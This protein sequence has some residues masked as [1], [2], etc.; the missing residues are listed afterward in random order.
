VPA[1][2]NSDLLKVRALFEEYWNSF[3]FP[4]SLQ[5]FATEVAGLPGQYEAPGGRLGLA[6]VAEEA[7]GCVALRRLDAQR[8]EAKRLYVR[9]KFRGQGFGRALLEWIGNEA[10]QA[11]YSEMFGDTLPVMDKALALYEQ[12][13]FERTEPYAASPT[14]GAIYL[15]LRL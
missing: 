7:A 3:G 12:M 2:S 11:G 9:Q 15:R 6:L 14:P 10:R 5:D 1:I 8:C 4:P 13:G